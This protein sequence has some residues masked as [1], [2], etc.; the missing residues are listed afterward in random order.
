M[1]KKIY[2]LIIGITLT[3]GAY[4]FSQSNVDFNKSITDEIDFTKTEQN[5]LI[6]FEF[7]KNLKNNFFTLCKSSCN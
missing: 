6:F 3:V 1:N 4:F 2:S 5:K 7:E